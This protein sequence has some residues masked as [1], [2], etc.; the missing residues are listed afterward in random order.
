[1]VLSGVY[2]EQGRRHRKAKR[3]KEI[4]A[5]VQAMDKGLGFQE[6]RFGE[7]MFD[8]PFLCFFSSPGR[9]FRSSDIERK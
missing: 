4:D 9:Y 1:M 5:V 6:G 8:T 7:L 2:Q 3:S